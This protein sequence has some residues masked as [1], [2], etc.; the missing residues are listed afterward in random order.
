M[1]SSSQ[2]ELIAGLSRGT[3]GRRSIFEPE[4]YR[5]G[6]ATREPADVAWFCGD[7]VV[8]MYLKGGKGTWQGHMADN[9]R[10]ARGWLKAWRAG[11]P[12][13]GSVLEG[14]VSVAYSPRLAIWS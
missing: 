1:L 5:K 6:S 4:Q 7:A 2:E 14:A 12:L 8:L 10:Q 13:Q 9:L 3:L 11:R